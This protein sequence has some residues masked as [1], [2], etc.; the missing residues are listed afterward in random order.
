MF[1][2]ENVSTKLTNEENNYANNNQPKP[3]KKLY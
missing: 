1:S 2:V 3:T